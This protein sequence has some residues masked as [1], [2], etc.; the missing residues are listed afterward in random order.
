MSLHR[1]FPL[2]ITFLFLGSALAAPQS[3]FPRDC[4][5]RY[6]ALS[7]DYQQHRKAPRIHV[8]RNVDGQ[9]VRDS[10]E[11]T[12]RSR[13]HLI[14]RA[15]TPEG[16]L[17]F[18]LDRLRGQRVLDI[19]AGTRGQWVQEMRAAGVEAVG[20]DLQVHPGVRHM[21]RADATQL[22]FKD[23]SFDV[24]FSNYGIFWG[25]Y[26]TPELQ[27][28]RIAALRECA[29]VLSPNGSLRIMNLG[30]RELEDLKEVLLEVPGFKLISNH[31]GNFYDVELIRL[32]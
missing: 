19:N 4:S 32:P 21:V 1:S 26:V 30:P 14:N 11:E 20:V 10:F 6:G 2:L 22:P 31:V 7:I 5:D 28:V 17:F 29:R 24:I 3:N 9:I 18:D 13:E 27:P 15:R 8:T 12:N 23:K 25:F 16:K